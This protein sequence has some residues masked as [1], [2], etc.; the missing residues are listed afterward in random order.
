MLSAVEGQ[1]FGE[2]ADLAGAN[3]AEERLV[4]VSGKRVRACEAVY[5]GSG[6]AFATGHRYGSSQWCARVR[7]SLRSTC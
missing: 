6:R 1:A 2:L 3:A 7:C 5:D 4:A